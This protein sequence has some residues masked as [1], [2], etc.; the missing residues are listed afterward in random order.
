MAVELLTPDPGYGPSAPV[1]VFQWE[2]EFVPL[3]DL[4]RERAPRAV[5][6]IGTYLGGTFY[7]WLQNARPGATVVSVDSYTEGPDN[8]RQY[9]D[10]VPDGIEMIAYEADSNNPMTARMLDKHAPFDWIF[11]DAGHYYA[12][13]RADW[14][15]FMPLGAPGGIIAFHD[16]L[17]PSEAWPMI[18]V[19]KLW[20]EIQRAGYVTR[21]IV[22]DPEAEWG[23]I[24]VVY[25]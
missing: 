7:H 9:F 8:R 19:E 20:R 3:L 21:E 16:I 2:A 1:A 17:P 14:E 22:A 23:G 15:N 4:Y 13:V 5:L 11:I 6:E 24:G 10:W 12:E 18:E 25:L